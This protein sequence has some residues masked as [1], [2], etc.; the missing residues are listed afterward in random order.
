MILRRVRGELFLTRVLN[1]HKCC[2]IMSHYLVG[3]IPT[4]LKNISSSVGMMKFPIWWESLIKFHGS[5]HHQ[6]TIK[7][8]S[9]PRSAWVPGESA[10]WL[11]PFPS[12]HD[13]LK[14][15]VVPPGWSQVGSASLPHMVKLTPT[16]PHQSLCKQTL[17]ELENNQVLIGKS[18][19]NDHVQ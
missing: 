15:W 10:S 18:T 12:S 14:L 7:T 16:I 5:S 8:A 4:P 17:R 11:P 1:K 3:G 19:I 2:S 13:W 6:P 9:N